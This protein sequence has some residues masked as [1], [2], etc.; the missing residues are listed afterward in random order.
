M[1][2]LNKL[3]LQQADWD[4]IADAVEGKLR[5]VKSGL[6][7]TD[8]LAKDWAEHLADILT[9][10]AERPRPQFNN[11]DWVEIYNALDSAGAG[12]LVAKLGP[13][14][15]NLWDEDAERQD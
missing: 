8:R 10:L 12:Q 9:E 1:A 11:E 6:Y 14:G 7:G 15:K 3:Q 5:A 2:K 13:D 4:T